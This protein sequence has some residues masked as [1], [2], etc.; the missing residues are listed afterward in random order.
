[1]KNELA[2]S[3]AY[4]KLEGLVAELEEG[5]IPLDKLSEKVKQANDLILI[6]E[7]KLRKIDTEIKEAIDTSIHTKK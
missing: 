4:T 3:E 5:D 6:C 7:N 1:M 2:Y